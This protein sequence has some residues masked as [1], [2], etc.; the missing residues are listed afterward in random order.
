MCRLCLARSSDDPR[1]QAPAGSVRLHPPPPDGQFV[2]ALAFVS[3]CRLLDARRPEDL[4][5][6]SIRLDK[7]MVTH[8][9]R[10][11]APLLRFT[12]G[13]RMVEDRA[14]AALVEQAG[15]QHGWANTTSASTRPTRSGVRFGSSACGRRWHRSARPS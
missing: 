6:K 11:R 13:A 8:V 2:D 4:P 3:F 5:T 10:V 9:A 15:G 1:A 12:L 7:V 14:L